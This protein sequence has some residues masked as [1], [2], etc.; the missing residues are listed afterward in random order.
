MLNGRPARNLVLWSTGGLATWAC[1]RVFVSLVK[2]RNTLRLVPRAQVN[3][4]A[5][6]LW[7]VP[8]LR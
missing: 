7:P 5:A 6:N 2:G 4:D 8:A 1:D 3:S